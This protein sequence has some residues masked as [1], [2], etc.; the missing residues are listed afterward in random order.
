MQASAVATHSRTTPRISTVDLQS[1]RVLP[2]A[3]LAGCHTEEGELKEEASHC[4]T[5]GATTNTTLL[6]EMGEG[7]PERRPSRKEKT[8]AGER[9]VCV[10][11]GGGVLEKEK[12]KMDCITVHPPQKHD[13]ATM[14]TG[15]IQ[16]APLLQISAEQAWP[17]VAL[18][19]V[20]WD[21]DR[22]HLWRVLHGSHGSQPLGECGSIN[23]YNRT[24]LLSAYWTHPS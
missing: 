19:H 15:E 6:K 1:P 13:T 11:G 20:T 10:W 18:R 16:N 5:S 9:C 7:G 21:R 2:Q 12:K 8:Q 14:E 4:L 17:A 24:E 23:V 22:H 3:W